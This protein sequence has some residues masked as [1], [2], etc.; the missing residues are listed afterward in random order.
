MAHLILQALSTCFGMLLQI[1][2]GEKAKS[3]ESEPLE[4]KFS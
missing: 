3:K 1:V 2:P 4:M